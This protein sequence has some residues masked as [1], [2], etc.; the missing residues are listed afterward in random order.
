VWFSIDK[1][2]APV[3]EWFFWVH[4]YDIQLLAPSNWYW[5]LGF[6]F[7]ACTYICICTND[8]RHIC[9]YLC[10]IC[11]AMICM[12]MSYHTTYV[13][14]PS[15]VNVC[16]S[17]DHQKYRTGMFS[18]LTW[19]RAVHPR[20]VECTILEWVIWWS[21]SCASVSAPPCLDQASPESPTR[22]THG[23]S[24]DTILSILF[25][26]FKMVARSVFRAFALLAV[27]APTAAFAPKTFG[28][29]K[30]SLRLKIMN[31]IEG[32]PDSELDSCLKA[33]AC[34]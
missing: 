10:M 24:S 3:A 22:T 34:V 29:K 9:T 16:C 5:I 26:W 2:K 6:V 12:H 13:Y 8:M 11:D 1:L 18:R 15:Y 4:S 25:S 19:Q 17:P 14:I 32:R 21:E 7:N 20:R 31:D 28:L 30:V 33:C 27:S 23:F